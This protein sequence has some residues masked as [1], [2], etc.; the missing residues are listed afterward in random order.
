MFRRGNPFVRAREETSSTHRASHLRAGLSLSWP[1]HVH[2]QPNLLK[3]C[4]AS[5]ESVAMN[6][7]R[8]AHISTNEN[9]ADIASKIVGGGRKRTYLVG[10]LLHDIE[11]DRDEHLKSVS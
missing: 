11:D 1:S 8:M 6:E 10:K 5:R 9:P 2:I 3:S 7:S 4:H